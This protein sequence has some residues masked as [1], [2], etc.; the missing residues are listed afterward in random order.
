MNRSAIAA[1]AAA[2][3]ESIPATD[4]CAAL[5]AIGIALSSFRHRLDRFDG[6]FESTEPLLGEIDRIRAAVFALETG[7]PPDRLLRVIQRIE[8]SA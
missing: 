4:P 7:L 6:E 8:V 3:T 1:P 5:A 2:P